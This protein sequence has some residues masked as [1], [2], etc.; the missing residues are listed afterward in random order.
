MD[1]VRISTTQVSDTKDFISQKTI[2]SM[3][4]HTFCQVPLTRNPMRVVGMG[5][6]WCLCVQRMELQERNSELRKYESL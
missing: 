1:A 6:D 4:I 3:K 2:N 5:Q